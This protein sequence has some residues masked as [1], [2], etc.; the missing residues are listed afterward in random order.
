MG[1]GRWISFNGAFFPPYKK[2][3]IHKL[4]R[5]Y[6][7]IWLRGSSGWLWF[8]ILNSALLWSLGSERG[9]KNEG[10]ARRQ[11]VEGLSMRKQ[12]Q[13]SFRNKEIN[14]MQCD[15][16]SLGQGEG[17]LGD[18]TEQLPRPF[19]SS[20]SSLTGRTEGLKWVGME[21][22]QSA[23][24]CVRVQTF[25]RHSPWPRIADLTGGEGLSV[26][27]QNNA[28]SAVMEICSVS[29]DEDVKSFWGSQD[30][31]T[32]EVPTLGQFTRNRAWD[33]DLFRVYS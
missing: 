14:S 2:H 20:T 13:S 5:S 10:G 24:H 16:M 15:N 30:G 28:L 21:C 4:K 8:A 33:G 12:K 19:E 25:K 23:C 17:G 26:H 32:E 31:I 29:I 9:K 1:L 27:Y 22:L 6:I 7:C 18:Q 11:R 3:D